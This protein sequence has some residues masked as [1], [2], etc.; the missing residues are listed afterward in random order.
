MI[1]SIGE[2]TYASVKHSDGCLF[3]YIVGGGNNYS[4][5]HEQKAIQVI[6][7]FVSV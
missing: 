4:N 5:N 1:F 7:R 3:F 6:D 2:Q